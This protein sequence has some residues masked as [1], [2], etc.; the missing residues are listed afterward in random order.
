MKVLYITDVG[1]VGGATRAIMEL[2]CEVQKLG[3]EPV[4]LTSVRDGLNQYFD[5]K[6]IANAACGYRS[7]ME[8]KSPYRWKRPLKY[9]YEFVMHRIFSESAFDRL[10]QRVRLDEIDIIHTN[11]AR[12]DIGCRIHRKYHIPHIMHFREFG[13]SDFG[14][15]TY[16][17]DY[18]DY[19]NQYCSSF[20]AV[21][22]AVKTAW[23]AKG[24]DEHRIRTIYDGVDIG[25]IEKKRQGQNQNDGMLK[26][27]FAGGVCRPKGQHVAVSAVSILPKSVLENVR[28]DII[29][30]QDDWYVKLLKD[31][32]MEHHLER[33]IRILGES[34]R[35][36]SE[37]KQYDVGLTCSQSE[38]FGRVTAEYMNAG[39]AVIVSDG[40]ASPELVRDGVDGLVYHRESAEELAQCITKLYNDRAFLRACADRA[41]KRSEY[42]SARRNA[43]DVVAVYRKFV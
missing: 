24:I 17:K 18:C 40:G 29:G 8:P 14:C 4:V 1:T 20:L 2:A 26:L 27:V 5:D 25:A 13:D 37:L 23:I 30:W 31:F 21:S 19:L 38:G 16:R 36:Y 22:D 3:V 11:S 43:E 33:Q 10:K 41:Q 42:F 39:L 12:I 9:P 28:L 15:N 6:G 32:I 35:L 7:V 34:K